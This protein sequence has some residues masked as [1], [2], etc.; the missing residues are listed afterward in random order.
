M[1]FIIENN[2]IILDYKKDNEIL[3]IKDISLNDQFDQEVASEDKHI[4]L[5]LNQK[6]GVLEENM[7]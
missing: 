4:S 1:P 2:E 7:G 5:S 6:E 3:N